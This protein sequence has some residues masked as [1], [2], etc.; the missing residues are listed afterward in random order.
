MRKVSI[1]LM[2]IIIATKRKKVYNLPMIL[3]SLQGPI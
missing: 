1:R 2:V 3:T